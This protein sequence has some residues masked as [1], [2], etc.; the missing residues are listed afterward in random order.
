MITDNDYSDEGSQWRIFSY[1]Q[2]YNLQ[3]SSIGFKS[4]LDLSFKL[5]CPGFSRDNGAL[6]NGRLLFIRRELQD[7]L[8][9]VWRNVTKQTRVMD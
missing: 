4:S 1:E 5:E 9:L 6:E 7:H 3:K 2:L 8:D